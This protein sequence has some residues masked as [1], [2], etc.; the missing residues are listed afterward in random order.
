MLHENQIKNGFKISYKT[1]SLHV[2]YYNFK[3]Q[4]HKMA[5]HTQIICRLLPTNC[6]SVFDRFVWLALKGLRDGF[7]CLIK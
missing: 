7:N 6:L 5:K 3:H 1:K 4:P 2:D